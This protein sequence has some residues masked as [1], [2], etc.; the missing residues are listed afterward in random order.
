M[1]W[2]AIHNFVFDKLTQ[3]IFRTVLSETNIGFYFEK[4]ND[5]AWYDYMQY[6]PKQVDRKASVSPLQLMEAS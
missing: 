5:L 4:W 3:S 1:D 2:K 6:Q